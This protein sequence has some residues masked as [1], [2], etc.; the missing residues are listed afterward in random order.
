MIYLLY[1]L[2]YSDATDTME[3]DQQQRQQLDT[4]LNHTKSSFSGYHSSY[5]ICLEERNR[6]VDLNGANKEQRYIPENPCQISSAVRG[7]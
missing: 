2:L 1:V 3:Y 4:G 6:R 5:S 7:Y